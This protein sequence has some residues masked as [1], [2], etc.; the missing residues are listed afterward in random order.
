MTKLPRLKSTHIKAYEV[1]VSLSR[2]PARLCDL[3]ADLGFRSY[4][5]LN[6]AIAFL[7]HYGITVV[8]T[9]ISNRPADAGEA[10]VC[11]DA[12]S[13]PLAKRLGQHYWDTIRVIHDDRN[14]AA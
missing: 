10:T 13:W 12:E 9:S 11:V 8:H 2:T 7:R 6:T 5:D 4:M 3:R 14:A 1:L